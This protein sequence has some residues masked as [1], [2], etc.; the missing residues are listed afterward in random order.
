MLDLTIPRPR[1]SRVTGGFISGSGGRPTIGGGA[2]G[3][4]AQ[5]WPTGTVGYVRPEGAGNGA[6]RARLAGGS[7]SYE[8]RVD[9]VAER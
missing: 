4:P 8:G 7:H 1:S 3:G 2:G 5:C 9:M 6:S